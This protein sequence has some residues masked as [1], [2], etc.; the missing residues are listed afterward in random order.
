MNEKLTLAMLALIIFCIVI[1]GL[2]QLCFKQVAASTALMSTFLKPI[3]W[4]GIFFWLVELLLWTNVLENVP[5]SIAF[6][7]MSLTYVTTLMAGVIVFKER[8]TKRHALGAFLIAAGV[9]CVGATGI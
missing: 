5:L 3:L 2:S 8:M 1:E 7:L 9:A 4:I 6:P